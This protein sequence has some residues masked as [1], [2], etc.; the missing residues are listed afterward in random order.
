MAAVVGAPVEA[1]L[2]EAEEAM[3]TDELE[4]G[5]WTLVALTPP[6]PLS[7]P[8]KRFTIVPPPLMCEPT[9]VAERPGTMLPNN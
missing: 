3:C 8:V 9:G 6:K 5:G 2:L 4:G 1:S 7:T